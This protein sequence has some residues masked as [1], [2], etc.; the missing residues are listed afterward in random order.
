MR[1]Q[2]AT[3]RRLAAGLAGAGALVLGAVAG[4][5]VS[6]AGAAGAAT[7]AGGTACTITAKAY[8]NGGALTM[9]APGS[10][11]WITTLRGP[12]Q[13]LVDTIAADQSLRVN[14]A[15]GSGLGW[16]ITATATTF[17]SGD[18]TLPDTGTFSFNGSLTSEAANIAPDAVCAVAA[19]CTLPAGNLVPAYPVPI[20]TDGTT[21]ATL[22]TAAAGS[23]IGSI[24][25][26]H[27]QPIGWWLNLPFDTPGGSYVSNVDLSIAS[28]P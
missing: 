14:D 15:T 7:C 20:T 22:Y 24:V 16:H 18:I 2:T 6:G 13:Q 3:R 5:A 11:S 12:A 21:I 23:G 9:I 27:D 19:T 8:L 26:G 10:L 17:T 25:L 28:G 4:L 1:S